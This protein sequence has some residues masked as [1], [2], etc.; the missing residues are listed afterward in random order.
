MFFQNYLKNYICFSF[1]ALIHCEE[2]RQIVNNKHLP[3]LKEFYFLIYFPGHLYEAFQ[4][5]IVNIYDV[6]WPFNNLAYHLDEQLVF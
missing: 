6:T 3:Y 4:K 1:L 5:T 2:F